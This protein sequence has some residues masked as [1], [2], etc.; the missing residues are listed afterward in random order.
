MALFTSKRDEVN[1][2]LAENIHENIKFDLKH[3]VLELIEPEIE[4]IVNEV[5]KDLVTRI[6]SYNDLDGTLKVN[7]MFMKDKK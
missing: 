6:E 1:K 5:V 3:R 2:I 4:K 7:V